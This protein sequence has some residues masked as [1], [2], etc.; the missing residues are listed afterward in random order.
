MLDEEALQHTF[1]HAMK[2]WFEPQIQRRQEP[3]T[4]PEPYTLHAAQVIL[5]ADGRP[6][7]VRL[8]EEVL[9][10]KLVDGLS[11]VPGEPIHV[12][13]M[14]EVQEIR[15]PPFADADCGHFT[16][17]RL[18]DCWY[19]AFDFR[20]NKGKASELLEAAEEFLATG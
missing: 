3:G 10:M 12:I 16:V 14:E 5:Y 15:L 2:L 6:R 20:Y 7:Q 1:A 19:G 18:G 11:K 13:E 8:N 9:P 17:I 4:A